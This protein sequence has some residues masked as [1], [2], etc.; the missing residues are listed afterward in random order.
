MSVY[1]DGLQTCICNKKWPY[2]KACHLVADSIEELHRFAKQLGLKRS[3]FQ[4][5]SLPHYDLT[6]GMRI[7]AVKLGAIEIDREKFIEI[8]R[9]YRP[10]GL[11]R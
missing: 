10:R 9:R 11:P 5:S 1:V 6:K 3:W 2:S 7:R 4:W 8:L